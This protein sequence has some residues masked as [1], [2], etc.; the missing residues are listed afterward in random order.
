MYRGIFILVI[1][2]VRD[3]SEH[4]CLQDFTVTLQK[5]DKSP[6]RFYYL[7]DTSTLVSPISKQTPDE[8]REGHDNLEIDSNEIKEVVLHDS[9]AKIL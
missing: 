4:S 5:L 7:Y 2:H 9:R 6:S 1:T 3:K 8:P